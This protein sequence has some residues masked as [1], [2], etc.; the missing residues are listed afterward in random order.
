MG[1][2]YICRSPYG[3]GY[4]FATDASLDFFQRNGWSCEP[5]SPE[6]GE[7]EEKG[8]MASG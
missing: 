8:V 4:K 6:K 1:R 2:L 7:R 3:T 5:V